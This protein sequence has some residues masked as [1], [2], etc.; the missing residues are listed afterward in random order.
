MVYSHVIGHEDGAGEADKSSQ[1]GDLQL[2]G[3]QS[4]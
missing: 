4:E 2:G 3:I 1:Q